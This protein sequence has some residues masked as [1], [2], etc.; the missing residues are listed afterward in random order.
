[1]NYIYQGIPPAFLEKTLNDQSIDQ[2]CQ[3]TGKGYKQLARELG[4]RPSD[5]D[6]FEHGRTRLWDILRAI[7]KGKQGIT[8]RDIGQAIVQV[9]MDI[10]IVKHCYEL[11]KR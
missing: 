4:F 9:G 6:N 10:S 5:I 1:M 8:Y 3:R 7:L 2:I 11:W